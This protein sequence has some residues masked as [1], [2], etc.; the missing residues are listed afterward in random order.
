[1]QLHANE[2]DPLDYEA[3]LEGL[4]ILIRQSRATEA[5]KAAIQV[6]LGRLLG[7]LA[8]RLERAIDARR[9]FGK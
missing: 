5:E 6:A 9:A 3:R 2:D 1:M 7:S 4:Q 8:N